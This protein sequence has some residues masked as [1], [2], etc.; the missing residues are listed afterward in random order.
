[1]QPKERDSVTSPTEK[2]ETRGQSLAEF[3]LILPILLVITFGII[4]FGRVVFTYA[5]GASALRDG[6]RYANILGYSGNTPGYQDCDAIQ[7]ELSTGLA[8]VFLGIDNTNADDRV[9]VLYYQVDDP[10]GQGFNANDP[11]PVSTLNPVAD[12]DPGTATPL[13]TDGSIPDFENGDI[14]RIEIVNTDITF[15]TPFL[16][17]FGPL[18]LDFVGQRSIVTRLEF[19][20]DP[21]DA[22]YDGLNDKWEEDQYTHK[23][24]YTGADE[25]VTG[26]QIELEDGTKFDCLPLDND[27]CELTCEAFHDANPFDPDTDNDGLSDGE[28]AYQASTS[29]KD[30]DTD[31]DGRTDAEEFF[32]YQPGAVSD[33]PNNDGP[34]YPPRNIITLTI[35]GLPQTFE[36][37]NDTG[38][39][40]NPLVWD[41]DGDGYGDGQELGPGNRSETPTRGDSTIEGEIFVNGQLREYTF[42]LN[43]AEADSDGDGWNDNLELLGVDEGDPDDPSDDIPQNFTITVD[44]QTRVLE[45]LKTD[46]RTRDTDGDFLWDNEEIGK[47]ADPTDSDTDDD[48]YPDGLEVRGIHP[49]AT[50][51][52][53]NNEPP[54]PSGAYETT[55]TINGQPYPLLSSELTGGTVYLRPNRSDS[56]SDG[57]L[58]GFELLTNSN[59]GSYPQP[60]KTYATNPVDPDTDGDGEDAILLAYGFD[61]ADI[62]LVFTDGAESE[63]DVYITEMGSLE[64]FSS[65]PTTRQSDDDDSS[66]S[67][68]GLDPTQPEND[69][70]PEADRITVPFDMPDSFE[71]ISFRSNPGKDDTDDDGLSD[72][73]ENYLYCSYDVNGDGSNIVETDSR[74]PNKP[75]AGGTG[76]EA[77]LTRCDDDTT[78][79]GDSDNDG[80][81]DWWEREHF[82]DLDEDG[83]GDYDS[84]GC[85]NLCE[86]QNDLDPDNPDT[87]GDTLTDGDEMFVYP[88]LPD[89]EDTDNDGLNDNIEVLPTGSGTNP[90]DQDS[91]DDGLTDGQEYNGIDGYTYGAEN[92]I[93]FGPVDLLGMG[94][95]TGTL[96][97]GAVRLDPNNRDSDGDGY[98]DGE[99]VGP[100]AS[101]NEIPLQGIQVRRIQVE[102]DQGLTPFFTVTLRP[103]MADTDGD[104]VDRDGDGIKE[105]LTDSDEARY[106]SYPHNPDTDGDTLLDNEELFAERVRTEAD[107]P[108]TDGDGANDGE[109]VKGFTESF[110][111]NGSASD[112]TFEPWEDVI[113][114]DLLPGINPNNPDTDVDGIPDG[115]E[116]QRAGVSYEIDDPNSDG[117]VTYSFKTYPHIRDSD[118]DCLT[119]Y[120]EG[121]RDG[122][123][124][125]DI[126]DFSGT[127]CGNDDVTNS[128]PKVQIE[129]KLNDSLNCSTRDQLPVT[130]TFSASYNDTDGDSIAV[131]EW[132]MLDNPGGQFTTDTDIREVIYEF[133]AYGEFTIQLR[134]RDDNPTDPLWSQEVTYTFILNDNNPPKAQILFDVNTNCGDLTTTPITCMFLDISSDQDGDDIVAWEWGVQNNP[135][136][137][138][139]APTD[140][141]LEYEFPDYG[142]YTVEFRVTDNDPDA[143][144]QSALET[145]EFTLSEPS[146]DPD[147]DWMTTVD[148][149]LIYNTD[150]NVSQLDCMRSTYRTNR[151]DPRCTDP[152]TNVRNG[153]DDAI[154]LYLEQ[155]MFDSNVPTETRNGDEVRITVYTVDDPTVNNT[156]QWDTYMT[157]NYAM[158]VTSTF[159][160]SNSNPKIYAATGFVTMEE[161]VFIILAD[162]PDKMGVASQIS[163]IEWAPN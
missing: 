7:G 2:R 1:M 60:G 57:L 147:E 150:P 50:G 79:N 69:M 83:E 94:E 119:D 75:F 149:D 125:T 20:T 153:F 114:N 5:L 148:E 67:I 82:G 131:Y 163:N 24:C 105:R 91:D 3:A 108:D 106:G 59:H 130:C 95:T 107:N 86:W 29:L 31:N 127:G 28:E 55:L 33:D 16:N 113:D 141:N 13:P 56:D 72:W 41:T 53:I 129:Q 84:D 45:E 37:D 22:D 145:L 118:E 98:F 70:P 44:G 73:Q 133:P 122:T 35:N 80:L 23:E 99:E 160:F 88:T 19:S 137:F 52:D 96:E 128:P 46:P 14:L 143:P 30:S 15:L 152:G 78:E 142:T 89:N 101:I 32:G 10:A 18:E 74:D 61:P 120:E 126:A 39:R 100:L 76:N 58:D 90:L 121:V 136:Q 11:D 93:A 63:R 62:Q 115:V 124:P 4:D 139:S 144:L 8:S 47:N 38:L 49:T 138:I 66:G 134:A 161:L 68:D 51:G 104:A 26:K 140:Q 117:T 123:D 85:D 97:A 112:V 132:I 111:I 158:D 155:G 103:D 135:G 109:E 54:F 151:G 25:G 9:H 48:Q 87:D 116:L 12:C 17:A 64:D 92:G 27:G 110:N 42:L 40:T 156:N 21:N 77:D 71:Y 102:V 146:A 157:D 36:R 34:R 81:P 6:V 154:K 159:T 162:S 65:N 43:P